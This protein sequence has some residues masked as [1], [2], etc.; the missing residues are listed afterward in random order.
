MGWNRRSLILTA[1]ILVSGAML[2]LA[3][4]AG[5]G[6]APDQT[7][8][9]SPTATPSPSPSPTPTGT[10]ETGVEPLELE[11]MVPQNG[12][13]AASSDESPEFTLG[14]WGIPVVG[15]TRADA[16]VTV[17]GNTVEVN[18][19][20][21]F[22][23]AMVLA[24]GPNLIEVTASDLMGNERN[25]SLVVHQV[26]SGDFPLHVFWPEEGTVVNAG[27]VPVIGASAVDAVVTINGLTVEVDAQGVFSTSLDLQEGPNIIEVIASD[28]LENE[29]SS[30]L[31]VYRA[32]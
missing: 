24:E 29:Q 25:I 17:N 20:G 1:S 10:P 13:A 28:L 21:M 3:A 23:H 26:A 31:V 4:C 9:P 7:P 15:F 11:V 14:T 8:A 12:I 27:S 32:P 19:E 22:V 5:P 6:Q 2:L 16:V 30:T 18:E